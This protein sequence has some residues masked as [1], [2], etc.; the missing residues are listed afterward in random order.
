MRK[1]LI[2]LAMLLTA[3]CLAADDR[4]T[5]T[6]TKGDA[7]DVARH[8]AVLADLQRALEAQVGELR[9]AEERQEAVNQRIAEE[10]AEY[11]VKTSA[12]EAEHRVRLATLE[13]ESVQTGAAL[14]AT[15]REVNRLSNEINRRRMQAGEA[16]FAGGVGGF[17]PPGAFGRGGFGGR[18]GAMPTTAKGE[19][20][21]VE[22]SPAPE[23]R[24]GMQTTDQKLDAILN[25]LEQMET[26][27]RRLE[28]TERNRR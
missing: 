24:P 18:G 23:G 11:K 7:K 3:A 10:N 16:P 26:R 22:T 21:K 17:A 12:L 4:A 20:G 9:A 5:Q 27:L 14:N 15:Q 25:K 6:D 28:A 1:T 13:K 19:R 8:N 2:G